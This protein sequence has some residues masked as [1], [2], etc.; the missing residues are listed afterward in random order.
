MDWC[1]IK[2]ICVACISPATCLMFLAVALE[3][4]YFLASW[5]SL[6][7][8][9]LSNSTLPSFMVFETKSSSCRK[10]QNISLCKIWAISG[11]YFV[12]LTCGCILLYHSSTLLDPWWKLL[13]KSNL[14]HTLLDWGLQNSSNPVQIVS[15]FNSSSV[16]PQDTYWSIPKSLLQAMTFLH[17]LYNTVSVQRQNT[18]VP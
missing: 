10:N 17:L 14:A 7:A 9:N 3:L 6:L 1:L 5:S 8:G 13:N 12:R 15:N 2:W 16:K 11:G 4:S 18:P